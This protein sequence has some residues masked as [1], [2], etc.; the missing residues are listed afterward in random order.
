MRINPKAFESLMNHVFEDYGS[1]R[2]HSTVKSK[3]YEMAWSA[4]DSLT[5]MGFL[6]SSESQRLELLIQLKNWNPTEAASR[7][8]TIYC[9][10]G[11]KKAS[12]WVEVGCIRCQRC[13]DIY[14][15]AEDD[16]L[17]KVLVLLR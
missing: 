1:G 9:Y 5:S 14:P 17:Q 7:K 13:Q 16:W 10:H 11:G 3:W 12:K 6:K 4:T 8:N 2:T 15:N